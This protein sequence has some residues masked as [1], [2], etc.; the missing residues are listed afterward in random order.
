MPGGW[1]TY[2]ASFS[3]QKCF[4]MLYSNEQGWRDKWGD[5]WVKVATRLRD[6]PYV[7]GYE[8][9]NEPWAGNM[10]KNPL[11]LDPTYVERKSL[12]PAYD[13]LNSRI[14]S[15]D[16]NHI[17]FF[18]PVTWQDFFPNGFVSAPG[19]SQ[20]AN[21]SVYSF[22]YYRP[23]NLSSKQTIK[24]SLEIAK[25]LNVAGMLTEF[26]IS[27]NNGFPADSVRT[28][29]QCDNQTVSWIGWIYKVT[30]KAV[31]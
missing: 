3:V 17:I 13:Y 14:R 23:P 7:V 16:P 26:W 31:I 2:Y 6:N 12:Q 20:F 27:L 24:S 22:H 21:R 29:E 25:S 8:L 30:K 1:A 19:G 28:L 9:I 15:V 4:Q 5:Y 11:I 10:Y 18:E